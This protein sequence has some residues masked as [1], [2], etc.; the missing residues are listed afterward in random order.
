M[1]GVRDTAIDRADGDALGGIE[2][3][4]AFRAFGRVDDVD[5]IA[6]RDRL[7]GAFGF[8]GSAVDTFF[9]DLVGHAI[10]PGLGRITYYKDFFSIYNTPHF[11]ASIF[12]ALS[13]AS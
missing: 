2:V 12:L 4:H 8:A 11:A 13:A 1:V 7:V 5:L 6:G 3:S 9:G 10:P